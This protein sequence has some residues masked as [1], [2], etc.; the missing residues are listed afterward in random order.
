M[1]DLIPEAMK[2][3]SSSN[4]PK[5]NSN[6]R[7]S[8]YALHKRGVSVGIMATTFGVNRRTIGHICNINSIFYKGIR[9]KFNE[10]GP[11]AFDK[12]YVTEDIIARVNATALTYRSEK[13]PDRQRDT[14]PKGVN[15]YARSKAGP[16][17]IE[18]FSG[19]LFDVLI[20]YIA[21]S[22]WYWSAP[23]HEDPN[24]REPTGPFNTSHI[25]YE[26]AGECL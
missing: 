3:S 5:M 23:E 4:S 10:M 26:N 8:V 13:S 9:K 14:L 21:S 24:M 2:N 6:E 11:E 17:I 7:H 22:G 16:H 1:T 18:G 25:A 20:D 15:P 12:E 19:N